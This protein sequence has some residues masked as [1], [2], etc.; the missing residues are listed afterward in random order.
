MGGESPARVIPS[1]NYRKMKFE[2]FVNS[3]VRAFSKRG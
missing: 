2:T 1:E 3:S